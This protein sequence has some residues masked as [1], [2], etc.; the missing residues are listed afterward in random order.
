MIAAREAAVEATTAARTV[1]EVEAAV[2]MREGRVAAVVEV[3]AIAVEAMAA[4]AGIKGDPKGPDRNPAELRLWV[5]DRG[6]SEWMTEVTN[7]GGGF[8]SPFACSYVAPL[9]TRFKLVFPA[10]LGQAWAPS[11][12]RQVG[13]AE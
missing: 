6:S 3:V 9:Q 8:S 10:D 2:V 13:L 5:G 4:A 12:Q 11:A 1:V 7:K